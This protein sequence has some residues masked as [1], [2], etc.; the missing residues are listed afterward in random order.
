MVIKRWSKC[1][2]IDHR[3]PYR[4]SNLYEIRVTSFG[5]IKLSV[6]Q[7]SEGGDKRRLSSRVFI[8]VNILEKSTNG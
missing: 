8:A 1:A 5:Y 2:T 7:D 4:R 3:S 6:E